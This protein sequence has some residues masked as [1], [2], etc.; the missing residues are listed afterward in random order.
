MLILY[1]AGSRL[2][3]LYGSREFLA[4]YLFSGVFAQVFYFLG[5]VLGLAP[6][7]PSIGASGAVTA[8]FVLYAFHFPRQQVLVFFVIPMPI[9]LV[10]VIY[11]GLDALGAMGA[12]TAPIAYFVHLGGALFGTVYYQ[13]G[14]RFGDLLSSR[15]RD[16][17]RAVPRLRVVPA[18]EIEEAFPISKR[19][20]EGPREPESLSRAG[21]GDEL[22]QRLDQVL[23]KVS[24]HGQESLTTEEREILFKASELYKKRRR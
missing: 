15:P 7:N 19:H 10:V 23:S 4:F 20:P 22:E 8:I 3:E 18:D 2:E 16:S 24:K 11:V 5:W 17:T 13:T 12:R 21:T 6:P 1:W 14:L 9:W